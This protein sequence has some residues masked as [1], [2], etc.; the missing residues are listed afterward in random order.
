MAFHFHRHY[1]MN[2]ISPSFITFITYQLF[3][4]NSINKLDEVVDFASEI[5]YT[6]EC[7]GDLG[8]NATGILSVFSI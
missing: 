1:I 2:F 8:C 5:G 6:T 7:N 3:S 4:L